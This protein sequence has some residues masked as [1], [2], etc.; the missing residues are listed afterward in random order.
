MANSQI[1]E[2]I[3]PQ[4][5][6]DIEKLLEDY[7]K[8]RNHDEALGNYLHELNNLPGEY[9]APEGCLLI[10]YNKNKP[11]GCVAYKKIGEEICEMKRLYVKD[12][13]R[14]KKI[15]EEL[16]LELINIARENKYRLMRL[17]THPWM[18]AAQNL[19]QKFGFKEV[20]RYNNN[21]TEGI[22]F[23]EMKL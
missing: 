16:V 9:S 17:D 19:Y 18:N 12:E 20:E 23:F 3:K 4:Q 5:L 11:A 8:L 6:S 21:P 22:R 10:A 2:A 15:G 1:Y 13:F 7:G 14:G